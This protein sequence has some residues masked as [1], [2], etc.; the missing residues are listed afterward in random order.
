MKFVLIISLFLFINFTLLLIPRLMPNY[1]KPSQTLFW[2]I[3]TN[4]LFLFSMVLPHQTSYIF[5]AKTA[6][7][8]F[9]IFKKVTTGE[10]KPRKEKSKCSGDSCERQPKS[11][12]GAGAVPAASAT[13][14]PASTEAVP[15]L[16]LQQGSGEKKSKKK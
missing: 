5:P 10:I 4:S 6:A 1:I 11:N 13:A 8:I 7:N 12:D 2:I 3:W 16:T 14:V 9:R 15:E